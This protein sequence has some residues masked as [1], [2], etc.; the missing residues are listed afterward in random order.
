MAERDEPG[1]GK[2]LAL[3][4]VFL[5]VGAPMVG[6]LWDA[7][8]EIIAGEY[9]RL[10]VFLPVLVVFVAFLLL[11]GRQVQRLDVARRGAAPAR[12]R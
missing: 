8:N 2:L 10:I 12:R 9:G 5:V 7:L 11:F 4:A 1:V 6:F 3:L